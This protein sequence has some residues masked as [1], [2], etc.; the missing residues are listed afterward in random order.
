MELLDEAINFAVAAHSGMYRK[1][2]KTPYIL[3]PMEA[4][5][6][7]GTMTDDA[8]TIAAAVL[9]DTVEDTD[10]TPEE[11][12][13]RFG[14]RV[15][16]LVGCETENKREGIPRDETWQARKEE[17]LELLRST[18]D[19]GVKILVLSDKLSN[20]RSFYRKYEECGDALWQDFHQK[21]KNKQYWY[22][23]TIADLLSDLKDCEAWKEYRCLIDKVFNKEKDQNGSGNV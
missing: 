14:D 2:S 20:M 19:I 16:F 10:V 8:E 21:D 15:A 13:D 23:D 9:H 4:A 12:R 3:H 17:T 6:I 5:A 7:A 1:K 22:Y 11:I 18:D